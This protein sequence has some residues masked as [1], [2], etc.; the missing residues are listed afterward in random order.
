LAAFSVVVI[1]RS[2]CMASRVPRRAPRAL[3]DV[4]TGFVGF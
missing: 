3:S 1:W 2:V 4:G